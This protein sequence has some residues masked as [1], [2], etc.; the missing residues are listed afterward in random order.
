[1]PNTIAPG[2]RKVNPLPSYALDNARE[3]LAA[4]QLA[5]AEVID[6]YNRLISEVQKATMALDSLQKEVTGICT[7]IGQILTKQNGKQ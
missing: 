5:H 1:M 6:E 4:F 3:R 7:G 2:R